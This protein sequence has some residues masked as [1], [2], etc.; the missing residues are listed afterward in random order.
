MN[1]TSEAFSDVNGRELSVM[2]CLQ[3]LR[4]RNA[5]GLGHLHGACVRRLVGRDFPKPTEGAHLPSYISNSTRPIVE[6][7]YVAAR[8]AWLVRLLAVGCSDHQLW[9]EMFG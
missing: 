9:R 6:A 7:R 5:S 8:H 4:P 2:D 1:P 3:V